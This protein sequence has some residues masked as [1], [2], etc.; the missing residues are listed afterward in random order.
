[1]KLGVR[2]HSITLTESGTAR[3]IDRA[4]TTLYSSSSKYMPLLPFPR[5][6]YR[7]KIAIPSYPPCIRRPR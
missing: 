2:G 6:A 3:W 1:M 7:S 4:H 5:A